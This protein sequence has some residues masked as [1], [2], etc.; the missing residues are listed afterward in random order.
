MITILI[1]TSLYLVIS[2]AF[3]LVAFETDFLCN[4]LGGLKTYSGDQAG[5]PLTGVYLPFA[6]Q[7]L[8]LKALDTMPS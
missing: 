3:C 8:D 6:S 5:L 7:V 2:V 1:A 4:S